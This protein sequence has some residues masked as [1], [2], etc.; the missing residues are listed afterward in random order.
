MAI[1]AINPNV[2]IAGDSSNQ[3]F[4]GFSGFLPAS[5]QQK[6]WQIQISLKENP[7]APWV[8]LVTVATS[9]VFK[10]RKEAIFEEAHPSLVQS[11]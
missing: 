4:R 9:R 5:D 3:E 6:T 7:A 10:R 1:P 11:I 2:V 8:F